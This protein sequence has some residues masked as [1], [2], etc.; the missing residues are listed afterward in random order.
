MRAL[1]E[2]ILTDAVQHAAAVSVVRVGMA[3]TPEEHEESEGERRWI[4]K[5]KDKYI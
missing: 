2:R 5:R 3:T 1:P 4:T